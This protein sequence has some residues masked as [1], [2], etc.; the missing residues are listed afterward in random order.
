MKKIIALVLMITVLVSFSG[1]GKKEEKIRHIKSYK[2]TSYYGDE[3]V[4]TELVYNERGLATEMKSLGDKISVTYNFDKY[5]NPTK[6]VAQRGE[7]D[8]TITLENEYDWDKLKK[9]II[10]SLEYD[11]EV[12]DLSKE[13]AEW[14]DEPAMYV[15]VFLPFISNFENYSD[16]DIECPGTGS[17][18]RRSDKDNIFTRTVQMKYYSEVTNVKNE[19]GTMI[20]TS[21]SGSIKDNEY[22]PGNSTF[23][24]FDYALF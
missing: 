8:F 20:T 10:T 21:I 22:V 6:A 18:I 13:S 3:S 4:S 14:R 11:N 23:R 9:V 7:E 5:D 24:G 17:V 16:I 12:F 1:C 15:S 2:S 19:D